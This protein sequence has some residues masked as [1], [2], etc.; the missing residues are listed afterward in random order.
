MTPP[1]PCGPPRGPSTPQ[2]PPPPLE[3][4]PWEPA[5]RSLRPF[6][7]RES[8]DT[9]GGAAPQEVALAATEGPLC[10]ANRNIT[11]IK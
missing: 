2:G 1:T 5:A 10:P 3:T 7:A 6:A 8:N 4:P 11:Y 9:F